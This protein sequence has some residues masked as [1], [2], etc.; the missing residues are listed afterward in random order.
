LGVLGAIIN[1]SNSGSKSTPVS[2]PPTTAVSA[3]PVAAK[4][5]RVTDAELNYLEASA[6]YLETANKVGTYVH[7]TMKGASNGS[8]TPRDIRTDLLSAK[9]I[10]NAA[11][12]GDYKGR[13][14]GNIPGSFA[15]VAT[16][17]DETHRLFQ[18]AMNELLEYWADQN[19]AHIVSGVDILLRCVTLMNATMEQDTEKVK[20]LRGESPP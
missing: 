20:Q 6:S 15:D 19:T 3:A 7:S 13:I 8:S 9:R 16:N 1:G 14:K 12:Q 10:E 18:A 17:I 2:S 4:P 11:Y 5:G